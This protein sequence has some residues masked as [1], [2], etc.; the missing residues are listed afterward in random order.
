M[1]FAGN[2]AI[3]DHGGKVDPYL[4]GELALREVNVALLRLGELAGSILG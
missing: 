4:D 3:R 2:G 1:W